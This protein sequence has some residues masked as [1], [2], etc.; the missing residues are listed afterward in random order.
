MQFIKSILFMC[1]LTAL[2]ACVAQGPIKAYDETSTVDKARLSI[3]YLPPE[4]EIV[5]ADGKEYDTPFIETGYNEIH[6]LPGKHNI[7]VKYSRFWGDA[8]S[9]G[10][11]S[12]KPVVY[13]FETMANTKY[14]MKFNKPQD[15]WSAQVMVRRFSPWIEQEGGKQLKTEKTMT[16]H[17]LLTTGKS[18][19]TA[20][21]FVAGKNPFEMLKFW[22]EN[23]NYAEKQEFKKWLIED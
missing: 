13:S 17:N 8:S 16:A 14:F 1:V 18:A 7:A 3:I 11:V 5:E 12:S 10:V 9:G 6:M 23:A 15:Q 4:I 20:K 21:Q 2:A 22:W 19:T